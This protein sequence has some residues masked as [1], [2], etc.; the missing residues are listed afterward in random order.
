MD[1]KER[2]LKQAVD[3]TF[4]KLKQEFYKRHKF[5]KWEEDNPPF[6]LS[7]RD[8][9]KAL[10]P[11]IQAIEIVKSKNG[12]KKT[13]FLIK[14]DYSELNSNS[15]KY[16]GLV[17]CEQNELVKFAS[18]KFNL[19]ESSMKFVM[20]DVC[21][22]FTPISTWEPIES[23][24]LHFVPG[25]I[26]GEPEIFYKEWERW[27][28]FHR[29]VPILSE[30]FRRDRFEKYNEMY[31]LKPDP[32]LSLEE[33]TKPNP[34]N[35]L[36]GYSIKTLQKTIADLQLI[37][38]VP[39]EIRTII[40]R[41][42]DLYVFGY[43]RYDF[44]TISLHYAYLGLEAAVKTRYIQSLG[45]KAM[46]TDRKN[47]ELVHK[48]NHPSF[49][50]I[51]GFC[52][53]SKGWDVRTLKVNGEAFPY[54]RTKLLAWLEKNHLIRKWEKGSYDAGLKLR[55]YFSHPE[56]PSTMTPDSKMLHVVIN[57]INYMFHN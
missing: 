54:S 53:N 33:L 38:Q 8:V 18:A 5:E 37:P 43:F 28:I 39:K 40:K 56:K 4:K 26:I 10:P 17:K 44:F 19:K 25:D 36:F 34:T 15:I 51:E 1:S 22:D 46:L 20:E 2:G 27:I 23:W 30:K 3:Y 9:I 55:N 13:G 31:D 24:Q 11:S 14:Y 29:E 21:S 35:V 42:K 12:E 49:F 6:I 7:L 52:R 50:D 47:N 41:A 45:E 32:I 16:C 48:M 57:E